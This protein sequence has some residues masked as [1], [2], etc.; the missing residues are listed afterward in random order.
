MDGTFDFEFE[1]ETIQA[2]YNIFMDDDVLI[3]HVDLG[4]NEDQWKKT[5]F[6]EIPE[7]KIYIVNKKLEEIYDKLESALVK[8]IKENNYQVDFDT[9]FYKKTLL[10]DN[11]FELNILQ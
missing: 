8:I 2:K 1:N 6:P 11:C 5:F 10:G 4:E 7:K 3:A 9:T